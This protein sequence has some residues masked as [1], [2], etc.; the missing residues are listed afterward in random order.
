MSLTFDPWVC[1]SHAKSFSLQLLI[2]RSMNL[3]RTTFKPSRL[4]FAAIASVCNDVAPKVL[5]LRAAVKLHLQMLRQ[6][7]RC[8]NEFFDK[9]PVGRI[10]A[11]F[12]KDIDVVDVV[13][14]QCLY[15]FC[16]CFWM[17]MGV[18]HCTKPIK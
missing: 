5:C 15:S 16:Y 11:R 8:P 7:L 4:F 2:P 12:S 1:L 10:I 18:T 14:P 17:V 13:L 6:I 3:A 9:T